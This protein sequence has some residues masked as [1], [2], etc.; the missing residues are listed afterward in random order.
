MHVTDSL[1]LPGV[2]DTLDRLHAEARSQNVRLARVFAV[3][4]LGRALGRRQSAQVEA[5]AA[6][7]LYLSISRRQGAFLYATVR[8]LRA[9]RVVEFGTSFGISTL[10]LA[11]GVRDNGGG[12]VIGSEI[13]PSKARAARDHVESA[14]LADCVEVREGDAL[15]TLRDPGGAV[16]LLF[17]DGSKELYLPVVELLEP[18]LGPGSVV[19]ADNIFSFWSALRPYVS[20]MQDPAHGFRSVTLLVTDGMEYSVKSA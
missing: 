9:R 4:L 11:A 16:D 2:R 7:R 3:H 20:R 10:Y 15:E 17:L 5:H 1:S 13:E 12:I 6:R 14:G 8:A 18:R 19:V